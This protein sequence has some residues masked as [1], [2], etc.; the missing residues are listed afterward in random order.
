MQAEELTAE[1]SLAGVR[2]FVETAHALVKT[3][4]WLGGV[5]GEISPQGMQMAAWQPSD[6]QPLKLR[7]RRG[8]SQPS[9][10]IS[11]GKRTLLS[12]RGMGK[13]VPHDAP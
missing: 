1:F 7:R 10:P 12:R 11:D 8:S 2:D 3:A 5:T 13:S 6:E 9:G 4:T